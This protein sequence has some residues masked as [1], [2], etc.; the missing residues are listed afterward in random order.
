APGTQSGAR[1][2]TVP[3]LQIVNAASTP[4]FINFMTE[5]TARTAANAE[6][7]EYRLEFEEAGYPYDSAL[8]RRSFVPDYSKELAL[9]IDPAALAESLNQE[10][11]YGSLSAETLQGIISVVENTPMENSA[12]ADGARVRVLYAILMVLASPDY[13]VQR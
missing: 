12:D 6:D 1:G 7:E 5:M 9:A 8:A 11:A 13:T 4:G 10:M 3:E 2:M